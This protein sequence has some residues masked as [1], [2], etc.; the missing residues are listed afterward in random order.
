MKKQIVSID[1]ANH[2][3]WGDS[4]DGWHLAQSDHLSVIQERVPG[5]CGEIRHYHQKSTQF[6]YVLSGFA[7]LEVADITYQL[8]P[9]QG[10]YVAAGEVHQ[11]RNEYHSDLVFLVI[12]T[13]PSHDDRVT[14]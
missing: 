4:C 11:L 12:S 13:P 6:F 10:L 5:G 9:F 3:A 8:K 2:Y 14:A 1:N 7:T